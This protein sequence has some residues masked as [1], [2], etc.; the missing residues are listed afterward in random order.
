MTKWLT[1]SGNANRAKA[2]PAASACDFGGEPPLVLPPPMRVSPAPRKLRLAVVTSRVPL[3]MTRA[4]QMTVAHWI[5][6]LSARGHEVELFALTG[7][8]PPPAAAM[9]WLER[10]CAKIHLFRRPRR[11]AGLGALAGWLRGLPL[12]VGYFH[13]RHQ[14][15]AVRDQA[16]R[17]DAVYVY[18]IR[19]AEVARGGLPVPTILAMQVSQTLNIRRMLANFRAGPEK[20][21]YR[22]EEPSVQRYESTIWRHFNRTVF[23]GPADLAAVRDACARAGRP[24]IDNALLLPH[25]SDL[26]TPPPEPADDGETIVFLGVLATNTNVEGVLWFVSAIWPLVR[27]ARPN[28][29][30]RIAGRRPR[31]AIRALHGSDGIEVL[32]EIG[33]PLP[34]LAEASVCIS[35]VRA[36][37]GMQNKLLDYFR[38]AKAV[39]ATTAA[40]EGI[41]AP[42][43][44]VIRLADRPE[45]FAARILHLLDHP[46]EREVLGRTAR[47]FVEDGWSWEAWFAKLEQAVETTVRYPRPVPAEVQPGRTGG[48]GLP[49]PATDFASDFGVAEPELAWNAQ[50][51]HSNPAHEP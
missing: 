19:S 46:A 36:A 11:R 2:T 18:Y 20:I 32:G 31:K 49:E 44:R 22:L 39:V 10:H 43:N 4:D 37:A 45:D 50:S 17:F 1:R 26:S 6:Y 29:R 8:T 33:D 34:F 14:A 12:Q 41:G 30:F 15:R 40:N 21:L 51:R 5:A 38:A 42:P 23:C 7:R 28:A 47:A 3:P 9:Q 16:H 13:D 24:M 25:G 27:V 48:Y 35:P